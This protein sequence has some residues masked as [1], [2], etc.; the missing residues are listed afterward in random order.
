MKAYPRAPRFIVLQSSTL[1]T[2]D[3]PVNGWGNLV[4]DTAVATAL[5]DRL[6]HHAHVLD[7]GPRGFR[8][9]VRTDLLPDPLSQ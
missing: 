1:L 2:S 7:C 9:E 5:L 4:A 3:R 6:M 8:T